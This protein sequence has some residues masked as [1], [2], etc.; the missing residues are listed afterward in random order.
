[1]KEL[2]SVIIPVY[3]VEKYVEECLYSVINQT[4][5]NL[6]IIV[7]DDG[8]TDGSSDLCDKFSLI[9]TRVQVIH[10]QNKGVSA[11]RNIGISKSTGKYITFVDSD[12]YIDDT[13]IEKLVEKAVEDGF[14][15]CG[16]I[17]TNEKGGDVRQNYV[18]A[19]V[20]ISE[21]KYYKRMKKN[22]DYAVVWGK[23][24]D[25]KLFESIRFWEGIQHEDEDIMPCLVHE[26]ERINMLKE[27]LYYYRIRENSIMTSDFSSKNLDIIPVCEKR[28]DR[29]KSWGINSMYRWAIK[30]YYLHLLKLKGMIS[31]M[32]YPEE[33]K[34]VN[35]KI[36]TWGQ[37][38][39]KFT[40][41]ERYRFREILR[42][43]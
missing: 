19:C 30:D 25:R 29:Y 26:S 37:Y 10:Q 14:V 1:M 42:G 16:K 21:G 41:F 27:S 38:G 17:S 8:S 34:I 2:V 4:Y 3:N 35:Q 23:L 11:A 15:M 20:R 36:E 33:Y 5:Q 31:K 12:D 43:K 28:I 22:P 24:Y 7:V 6:E 32:D 9:D 18:G 40:L 13:M 39:V